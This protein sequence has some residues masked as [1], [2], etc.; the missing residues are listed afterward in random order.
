MLE[1]TLL[2]GRGICSNGLLSHFDSKS[3]MQVEYVCLWEGLWIHR[4]E[5]EQ[6]IGKGRKEPFQ[7]RPFFFFLGLFGFTKGDI[8]SI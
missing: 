3:G 4:Q 5:R 2:S 8:F 1:K 6:W 7:C